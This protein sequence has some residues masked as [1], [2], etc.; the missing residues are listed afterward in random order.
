MRK[1]TA[2]SGNNKINF[3]E[4][5]SR[6]MII[7]RRQRKVHKEII[8][9]LNNK[10]LQQVSTEKDLRIVIDDKFKFSKHISYAAERN[11]K[12]IHSLQNQLNCHGV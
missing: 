2:W 1:I 3:N 10:P 4:D 5:K 6:I 11:S 7:S 12:L 8:I 9:Y